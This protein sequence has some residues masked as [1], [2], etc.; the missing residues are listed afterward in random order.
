MSDYS[1]T[2]QTIIDIFNREKSLFLTGAD[3]FS[4]GEKEKDLVRDDPDFVDKYL[5]ADTCQLRAPYKEMLDSVAAISRMVKIRKKR[6]FLHYVAD[7]VSRCESI[8]EKQ[9]GKKEELEERLER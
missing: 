7:S 2:Q 4:V 5:A 6:T 8:V 1:T 9:L 3:P